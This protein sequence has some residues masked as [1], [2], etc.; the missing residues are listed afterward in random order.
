MERDGFIQGYH[1]R[2]DPYRLGFGLVLIAEVTLEGRHADE[3]QRFEHAILNV[4][5]VVEVSDVSGDIDYLLKV[6]VKDMGEWTRLKDELVERNV[7]VRR[8]TTHILMRK[9]KI[10]EGYPLR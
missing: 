9:P 8:I 10:F 3:Q 7:G 6:V 5:N 4:P 2:L 1:A